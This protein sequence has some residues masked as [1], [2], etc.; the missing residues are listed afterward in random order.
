MILREIEPACTVESLRWPNFGLVPLTFTHGVVTD[1]G[2]NW[3]RN[4]RTK[5]T[6]EEIRHH[7]V[8]L[9]DRRFRR[10]VLGGSE[11]RI[12]VEIQAMREGANDELLRIL[13][14]QIAR[15]CALANIGVQ[16]AAPDL[17]R[18]L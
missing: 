12:G 13:E 3:G 14:R 10:G 16:P 18:Y 8:L 17:H 15:Q 1:S 7:A 2:F 4:L 11:K 6:V 5:Q 9:L